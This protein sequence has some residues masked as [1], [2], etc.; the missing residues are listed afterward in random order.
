MA[1][2]GKSTIARTISREFSKRGNLVASFFFARGGADVAH[3]GLF[4]TSIAKQLAI[5]RPSVKQFISE[6]VQNQSDIASKSRKAAL[7][8]KHWNDTV[9]G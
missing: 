6:A 5:A 9:H 4:F 2:T 3:T 7:D 8:S 1:G